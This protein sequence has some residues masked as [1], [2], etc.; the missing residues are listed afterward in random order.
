MR[1]AY[2]G[3]AGKRLPTEEE[4]EKAARGTDGRLWPWGDD[5]EAYACKTVGVFAGQFQGYPAPV[6]M[7]WKGKRLRQTT[8]CSN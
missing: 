7:S 8:R 2:A 5:W 4:W 1:S 3:W 6:W